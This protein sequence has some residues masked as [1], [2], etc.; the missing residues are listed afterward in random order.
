MFRAIRAGINMICC[1][2]LLLLPALTATKTVFE[3][4]G[5]YTFYCNSASSQAKIVECYAGLAVCYKYFLQDSLTGES[6]I[7]ARGET[8]EEVMEKY[9]ARK[10]FTE[11]VCGI[12]NYYCYTELLP[13]E[14]TLCGEKV[15]LH[16]AVNEEGVVK[17]GSPLIFGGY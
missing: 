4:S 5:R 1:Y 6:V 14:T 13:Y 8:A 7:C 10:L 3:P 17:A 2:A 9:K 16:V 11:T 15:S 12:T